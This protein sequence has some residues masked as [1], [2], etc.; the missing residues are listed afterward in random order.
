MSETEVFRICHFDKNKYYEH[1]LLTKKVGYYPNEK[2]YTTNPLQ[3][4]GKWIR[5]ERWG[6][7]DGSGGAEYFENENGETR[8]EYTY[9][10]T[11]CFR[12]ITSK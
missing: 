7:G 2:Y 5:S 10:G 11:T 1:A 9:E 4:V 8:I 3:Y 12:E 6:Y